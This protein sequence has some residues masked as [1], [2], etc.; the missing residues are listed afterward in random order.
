MAC[1]TLGWHGESGKADS[2]GHVTV[3]FRNKAGEHITMHHVYSTNAG[4]EP[5]RKN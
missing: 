2:G 5:K 3:D 1:R 4:Y